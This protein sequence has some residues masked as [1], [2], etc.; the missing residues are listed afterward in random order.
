MK[1]SVPTTND[2]P[3]ASI[4]S[5]L[6]MHVKEN[7]SFEGTN[8]PQF[9][10]RVYGGQVFAQAVIAAG[11]SLADAGHPNRNI[12]SITAAFLRPGV[13]DEPIVFDVEDVLDGRSF[14]TRRIYASQFG[15]TI[16]SARASFQEDQPGVSH[17]SAV[18]SAPNPDELESSVD[19]FASLDLPIARFMSSTNAIDMR[20]VHGAIWA[21]PQKEASDSTLIWFKLRNPMPEESNQLLHRAILAYATDQFMLEPILRMHNMSW[22]NPDLSLATLDHTIWWHRNVNMSDWILTELKSPSAQG[23]RG[24]SIAKFFQNGEHIATMAQEGMVR[25]RHLQ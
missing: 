25:A 7:D 4:L 3:L 2:E 23:G 20:H 1:I 24:L 12:H 6:R 14:S 22:L 16:L 10:G 9:S 11:T 13:L 19:F 8:L 17:Q 18:P 15:Q 5:T 21:K